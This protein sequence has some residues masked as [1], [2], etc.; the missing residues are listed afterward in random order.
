MKAWVVLLLLPLAGCL[1]GPAEGLDAHEAHAIAS[2]GLGDFEYAL[3]LGIAATEGPVDETAYQAAL[4]GTWAS[5]R[6]AF[7]PAP[8]DGV[9]GDGR[10]AEWITTHYVWDQESDRAGGLFT[11]VT[12]SGVQRVFLPFTGVYGGAPATV[13]R[14]AGGVGGPALLGDLAD[15][16]G[17]SDLPDVL[18]A[19]G[20][21][22]RLCA[23]ETDTDAWALDADAAVRQAR[24]EPSFQEHVA[25]HPDG[26]Y[27]YA[28]MPALS[29]DPACSDAALEGNRWTVQHTDLDGHLAGPGGM[30]AQ[31]R[32]DADDGTVLEAGLVRLSLPTVRFVEGR[33]DIQDPLVPLDE[34]VHAFSFPVEEGT[35]RLDL[36][37]IR[38]EVPDAMREAS[39]R[40]VDPEGKVRSTAAFGSP[41][42]QHA[43]EAPGEG[44]W[45]LEYVY[46]ATMPR[47]EHRVDVFAR[48]DG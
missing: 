2:R 36:H 11:Q 6:E 43:V 18:A 19:G 7:G 37:A 3:F 20:D 26:Q 27:T 9:V 21:G 40:L 22:P 5:L 15:A 42:H 16:L 24:G 30:A 4:E 28:Y 38:R 33:L 45:R 23:L 29:V 10:A 48:L 46:E 39:T 31:V 8:Q 41:I 34:Q 12:P 17:R 47:G 44:T 25:G 32:V 14:T 35:T 1:D 13:A